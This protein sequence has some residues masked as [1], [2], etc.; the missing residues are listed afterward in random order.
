MCPLSN[1]PG[2]ANQLVVSQEDSKCKRGNI[3]GKVM[4]IS[5][6]PVFVRVVDIAPD[7]G[8]R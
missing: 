4:K 3:G 5:A 1:V 7:D 8:F 6:Q 2:L